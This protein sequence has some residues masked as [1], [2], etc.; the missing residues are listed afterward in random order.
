MPANYF[1]MFLAKKITEGVLKGDVRALAKAI[2]IVENTPSAAVPV[3]K[4]LYRE[5]GKA[6]LIGITGSPGAGKSALVD[7]M[8]VLYR[9]EKKRVAVV[10]VDPSSA[11]S[12]G[13]ILGDRVRMQRL[14][15][16]PDIFIR[17]MATRGCVGGLARAT[18]DA[19]DIMDAFGFEVILVETVGVGQNEI[20]IVKLAHT[21]AVV[22]T[23][24]MGDEIQ[25]IKAG[26]MEIA[27][28]FVVNKSDLPGADELKTNLK[29]LMHFSGAR[30]NGEIP[31]VKTV[32]TSGE[33]IEELLE[34]IKM[35]G[36][37]YGAERLREK[38]EEIARHRFFTLLK[39]KTMNYM[40]SEFLSRMGAE[41]LIERIAKRELDPHSAVDDVLSRLKGGAEAYFDG[42]S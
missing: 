21:I 33:G 14:S 29:M 37:K 42:G 26:I 41:G 5:T 1:E 16:D 20:D 18:A 17:S 25:A 40:E 30:N 31:I 32:A 2:S 8:A 4:S 10:A 11:F 23:P 39:E 9:K 6:A 38:Y 24:S 36:E 7:K 19:I 12:G 35:T 3:M 34:K 15:A 28:L 27:D 22:L 13:A